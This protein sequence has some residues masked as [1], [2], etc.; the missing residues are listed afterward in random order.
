VIGYLMPRSSVIRVLNIVFP[1]C[2]ICP[3]YSIQGVDPVD[4][5]G[6][7]FSYSSLKRQ[8]LSSPQRLPNLQVED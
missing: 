8:V 3:D 1:P 6:P 5:C 4:S 7:G 2:E